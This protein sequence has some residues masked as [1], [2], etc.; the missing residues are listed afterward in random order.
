MLSYSREENGVTTLRFYRKRNTTDQ[1]DVVIQVNV[2]LAINDFACIPVDSQQDWMLSYSREEN[3]V[4]T[5]R[6]YRKRNT[7]D[8][9]DVVIQV[10][11]FLAINDFACIRFCKTTQ[12]ICRNISFST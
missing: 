2:F 4:T 3:G 9:S 7:T 8:Q 11:V 5:L 1:S 6:F 10:N 12:N